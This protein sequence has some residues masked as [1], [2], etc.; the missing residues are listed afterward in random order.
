MMVEE[1]DCGFVVEPGSPE[2][3]V[4]AILRLKN[5]PDLAAR[6]GARGFAAYHAKYTLDKAVDTFRRILHDATGSP[7]RC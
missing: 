7:T 2:A 3:V 4:N 6:M 1:D 5:D